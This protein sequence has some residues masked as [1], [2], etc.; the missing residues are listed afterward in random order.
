M[1]FQLA[2]GYL[3]LTILSSDPTRVDKHSAYSL[4][5]AESICKKLGVK[6]KI[7]HLH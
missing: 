1:M 6:V 4:L 3:A 5:L 7:D 2:E